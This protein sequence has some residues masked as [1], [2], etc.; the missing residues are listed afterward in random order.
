MRTWEADWGPLWEYPVLVTDAV[1]WLKTKSHGIRRER[2]SRSQSHYAVVGRDEVPVTTRFDDIETA[3]WYAER[4]AV[5]AA[6]PPGAR[7]RGR[8]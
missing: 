2:D 6:I 8:I 4:V 5:G 1:R 3:V 7:A